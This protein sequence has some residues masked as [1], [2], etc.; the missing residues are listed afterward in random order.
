M[1]PPE[2]DYQ[3]AS[4]RDASIKMC[5]GDGAGRGKRARENEQETRSCKLDSMQMTARSRSRSRPPT[6]EIRC[7]IYGAHLDYIVKAIFD[8][9]VTGQSGLHPNK[10]IPV[11]DVCTFA[12]H[13]GTSNSSITVTF[14]PGGMCRGTPRGGIERRSLE[15][16]QEDDRGRMARGRSQSANDDEIDSLLARYGMSI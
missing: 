10:T 1:A 9:V 5:T 4:L 6:L 16:R 8:A 12:P 13:R 11:P 2:A 7:R 15:A 14:E 3:P